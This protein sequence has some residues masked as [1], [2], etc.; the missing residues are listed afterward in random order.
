M[1]ANAKQIV[2]APSCD[3]EPDPDPNTWILLYKCHPWRDFELTF[4]RTGQRVHMVKF[5]IFPNQ[6]S[7]YNG[8][9]GTEGMESGSAP[10]TGIC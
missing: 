4:D 2:I 7:G 6:D 10:I 1:Y 3:N 5:K 9:Y 8:E